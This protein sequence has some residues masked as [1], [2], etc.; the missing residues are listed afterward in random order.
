M[1]YTVGDGLPVIFVASIKEKGK[2]TLSKTTVKENNTSL[3]IIRGYNKSIGGFDAWERERGRHS[4][5]LRKDL[6]SIAGRDEKTP[7]PNPG[8]LMLLI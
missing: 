1:E 3:K 6:G 5:G 2:S 4:L 8:K 7:A